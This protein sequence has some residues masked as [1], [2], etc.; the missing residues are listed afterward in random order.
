M[1]GLSVRLRGSHSL[2]LSLECNLGQPEVIEFLNQLLELVPLT[3]LDEIAIGHQF[4]AL[5]DV[6]LR[7]RCRQDN[8]WDRLQGIYR[9]CSDTPRCRAEDMCRPARAN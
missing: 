2:L 8:D 4:V 5:H 1:S 6:R 7:M 3:G 9:R